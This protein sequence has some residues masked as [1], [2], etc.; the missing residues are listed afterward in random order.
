LT[1]GVKVGCFARPPEG[2][3]RRDRVWTGEDFELS[4]PGQDH[5]FTVFRAG[6]ADG[7]GIDH[8]APKRS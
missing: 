3:N 4:N 6:C 1:Q 8:G 5:D 7:S 2:A